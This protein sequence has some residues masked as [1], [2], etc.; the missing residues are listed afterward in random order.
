MKGHNIGFYN[1]I[2]FVMIGRQ[3]K[4]IPQ[5]V[6]QNVVFCLIYTKC[7]VNLMH[8]MMFFYHLPNDVL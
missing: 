7:C 6:L 4:T 3:E 8:P 1:E 2:C 5:L